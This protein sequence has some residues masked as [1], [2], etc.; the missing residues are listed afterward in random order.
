MPLTLARAMLQIPASDS[1]WSCMLE[2][3]TS[4][5]WDE[6][7]EEVDDWN[8][9]IASV[10]G[11][12]EVSVSVDEVN[13]DEE[14]DE[15]DSRV[16]YC[17]RERSVLVPFQ[18]ERG[19]NL[20]GVH[21]LAK[22]VQSDS[23]LRYCRDSWHSSDV[24]FLALAPTQWQT[25]EAEF[26]REAVER[27]FLRVDADFETFTASAFTEPAVVP[28]SE[29][30]STA[31]F[32]LANEPD[33]PAVSAFISA[34]AECS[35]K[36]YRGILFMSDSE[37]LEVSIIFPVSTDL[38]RERMLANTDFRSQLDALVF[39]ARAKGVIVKAV[40]VESR[41]TLTREMIRSDRSQS[42]ISV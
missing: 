29:P 35:N 6:H 17:Y 33:L 4:F 9:M 12:P 2:S 39:D 28:V 27:R 38:K 20:I 3:Q 18:H 32:V 41:E 42:L 30:V 21:S 40:A 36:F 8:R 7:G 26:G 37:G 15:D 11:L 1:S 34:V 5:I 13:E 24:A 31:P 14:E 19:D 22:L 25:L 16:Y 23:E 10:E